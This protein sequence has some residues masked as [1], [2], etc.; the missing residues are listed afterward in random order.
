MASGDPIR[1]PAT[2]VELPAEGGS[3]I[4]GVP[5]QQRAA[6]LVSERFAPLDQVIPGFSWLMAIH[7]P[8]MHHEHAETIVA[9]QREH[10]R[11]AFAGIDFPAMTKCWTSVVATADLLDRARTAPAARRR[12]VSREEVDTCS[13]RIREHDSRSRTRLPPRQRATAP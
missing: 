6:R 11:K 2:S 10:R 4:V 7:Q 5:Q 3:S 8:A 9:A 13:R 12:N 1:P